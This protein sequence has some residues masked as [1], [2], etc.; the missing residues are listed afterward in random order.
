MNSK[1]YLETIGKQVER[2]IQEKL[3]YQRRFNK[4]YSEDFV[5]HNMYQKL[6][7]D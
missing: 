2:D 6:V 4:E 1:R 7:G 5:I 3:R